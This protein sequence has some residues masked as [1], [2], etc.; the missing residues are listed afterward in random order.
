M[1]IMPRRD[2]LRRAW[3]FARGVLAGWA[4]L[5]FLIYVIERYLPTDARSRVR[6]IIHLTA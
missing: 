5:F 1:F 2:L 3:G 6:I 4:A